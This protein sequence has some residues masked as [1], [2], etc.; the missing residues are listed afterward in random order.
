MEEDETIML[1]IVIGLLLLL[2][3]PH[4]LIAEELPNQCKAVIENALLGIVS[5]GRGFY[6]QGKEGDLL[7]IGY[8]VLDVDDTHGNID[9]WVKC[10][11]AIV[12][13]NGSTVEYLIHGIAQPYYFRMEKKYDEAYDIT[14][15][16]DP[17]VLKLPF[18]EA[19]RKFFPGE[20]LREYYK[21]SDVAEKMLLENIMS[22]YQQVDN[23]VINPNGIWHTPINCNSYLAIYQIINNEYGNYPRYAGKHYEAKSDGTFSIYETA[24]CQRNSV[25][26][27]LRF[28]EYDNNGHIIKE[29]CR[30]L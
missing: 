29:S 20:L 30:E 8:E 18:A 9:I 21:E 2:M 19:I 5:D 6:T 24:I 22:Y 4:T 10:D 27:K 12:A 17:N 28:V 26:E 7:T 15:I 13:R 1:R 16:G 3:S 23:G 14:Y 11:Y 25:D